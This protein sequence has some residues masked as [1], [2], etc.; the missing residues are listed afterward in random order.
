MSAIRP[1]QA[2]D[3][4]FLVDGSSFVFRAYFQSMRQDQKY[5]Y[6]SDKLPTGAVRL[7]C[8]KLLQFVRE[9][10]M[11]PCP[12][13]S[14]SSSTSRRTRSARSSTPTTRRI[15]NEPPDDLVPQ[16]PLMR[17]AVRA[18]GLLPV[19]QDRYEADDLIATY[20]RLARE[21]GADVLI[22]SADKDLMQV[23]TDT[24]WMYDPAS[25]VP[26]AQGSRDERRIGPADVVDYFGV[27]P[28]LVVD[29]Q[30][31]AG[32]STDNVPGAPGIGIKTAAQLLKE[33]GSLDALMARAHEIK[34]PK[35]REALTLPENVERIRISRE[36]VR[37]CDDVVLETPLDALRLPDADPARLIG[38]CKALEFTTITRRVAEMYGLD[39]A[40]VRPTPS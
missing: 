30:A 4:V 2:G 7:F 25:G 35:R 3:H 14:P 17:E 37:L 20:A 1:V 34:Q 31:L 29:V 19:E 38:F 24:V 27:S 36:L 9:G 10:A 5:N 40:S 22:V 32:D 26:G 23:V 11:G 15:A 21:A 13:I 8:T 33:Y 12:P 28:E 39:H 6:R 18:F 16:F